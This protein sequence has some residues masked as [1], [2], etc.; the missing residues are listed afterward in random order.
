VVVAD[1]AEVDVFDGPYL[2]A[3][4][5]WDGVDRFDWDTSFAMSECARRSYEAAVLAMAAS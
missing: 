2:V 5:T 4:A 3:K 1:M